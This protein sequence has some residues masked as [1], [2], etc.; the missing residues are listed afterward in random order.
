[1]RGGLLVLPEG[2]DEEAAEAALKSCEAA[3]KA[4][5]G[6]IEKSLAL[7]WELRRP[8]QDT[9]GEPAAP[10]DATSSRRVLQLLS[11]IPHGVHKYSHSIEGLPET[12]C[13]L[14]VASVTEDELVVTTTT[15]SSIP[16]AMESVRAQMR[17]VAEL[18]GGSMEARPAYS[19]WQ[20]NLESPL[21]K[22]T[23]AAYAEVLGR[24]PVVKASHAGLE[25]GVLCGLLPGSDAV[26]IGPEIRGAHSVDERAQVSTVKPCYDL[27]LKVLDSLSY[28]TTSP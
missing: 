1:M 24:E 2:A 4:E 22:V 11:C 26:S 13:N 21:L 27:V 18:C 9:S 6:A 12:S 23:K 16:A 5:Y 17:A 15:R 7:D 25:C 14:A 8:S 10:M 28:A 20:P 19:G 3:F